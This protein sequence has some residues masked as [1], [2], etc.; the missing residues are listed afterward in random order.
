MRQSLRH[1]VLC[2]DTSGLRNQDLRRVGRCSLCAHGYNPGS[3]GIHRRRSRRICIAATGRR[4]TDKFQI[5]DGTS[6]HLH[7]P[8]SKFIWPTL[9]TNQDRP[10]P[11]HLNL[12]HSR[13]VNRAPTL[14]P[15]RFWR[16]QLGSS[17]DPGIV[18]HAFGFVAHGV[19]IAWCATMNGT[20]T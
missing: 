14:A 12:P 3:S 5:D 4:M 1:L 10:S 8:S 11:L 15:E 2:A 18:S 9:L 19:G 16:S 20:G 7:F 17:P 13:F 6:F